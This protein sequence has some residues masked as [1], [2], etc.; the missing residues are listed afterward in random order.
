MPSRSKS[1]LII[2]SGPSCVGKSPL[3]KALV[4]FYPTLRKSMQPLILYNDR[5]KRPGEVDGVDYHFRSR[6]QIEKLKNKKKF[7]VMDVRGDLQ[8][9][10][11]QQLLNILEEGDVFFEGNPFIGRILLTH[12]ALSDLKRLSI[13]MS[14][15]SRDEIIFLKSESSISI[16]SLVIDVMRRKLLRRTRKQ[17]G[18]LSHNDLK[19]IEVR[20]SS[21]YNELKEAHNF[22]YVIPNHDGEDCENWDAFYYPLG[23][24]RRALLAFVSL[25]N[26]EQPQFGIE[27][28]EANLIS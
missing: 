24:A 8:A 23:D 10:D 26:D 12:S 4:K 11:V 5:D 2:L 15:L 14:P 17:K 16:S 28:W 13:F 1:R 21:A 9:L 18:E 20:A 25:L 6:K 7:V 22:Q 3:D 27:N 19:N